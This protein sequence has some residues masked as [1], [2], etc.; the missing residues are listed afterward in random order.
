MQVLWGRCWE[1][2]GA[3]T[4]AR[5]HGPAGRMRQ[6]LMQSER[7]SVDEDPRE[8]LTVGSVGASGSNSRGDPTPPFLSRSILLV[9]QKVG[10]EMAPA[11]LSRSVVQRR[12][13]VHEMALRTHR[14]I[15]SSFARFRHK[16]KLM[17]NLMS[18]I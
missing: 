3:P 6:G 18:R 9:K 2:D 15:R 1:G 12:S 17:S 14:P 5:V 10:R 7:E 16:I 8:T 11:R 13:V 4:M